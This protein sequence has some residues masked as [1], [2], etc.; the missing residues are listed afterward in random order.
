[1]NELKFGCVFPLLNITEPQSAADCRVSG[2]LQI[3]RSGGCLTAVGGSRMLD[4]Q[5]HPASTGSP[6][7]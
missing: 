5:E 6:L 4:D 2:M 3:R 7:C 1:M